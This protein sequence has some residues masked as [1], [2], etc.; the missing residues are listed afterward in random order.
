[1]SNL[2]GFFVFCGGG[3]FGVFLSRFLVVG[4]FG[5]LFWGV[6]W[7]GLGWVGWIFVVG[8]MLVGWGEDGLLHWCLIAGTFRLFTPACSIENTHASKKETKIFKIH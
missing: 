1:M 8:G 4:G 7:V 5:F 3:C 2:L 6:F